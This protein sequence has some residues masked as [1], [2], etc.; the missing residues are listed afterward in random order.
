MTKDVKRV[1]TAPFKS[2][3]KGVKVEEGRNWVTGLTPEQRQRYFQ[4]HEAK[5][6]R[7]YNANRGTVNVNQNFT[8]G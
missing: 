1:Q 8:R 7:K 5:W 4:E 3:S 6:K 2:E